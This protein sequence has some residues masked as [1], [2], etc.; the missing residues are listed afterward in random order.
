[1]FAAQNELSGPQQTLQQP[2]KQGLLY[3][4]QVPLGILFWQL[5]FFF[6]IPIERDHNFTNFN[7]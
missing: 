7:Y 6:Y 1:M 3:R 2:W 4:L 5:L